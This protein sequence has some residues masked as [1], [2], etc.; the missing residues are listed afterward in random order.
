MN[1]SLYKFC[2]SE[3][4]VDILLLTG[5]YC[6]PRNGISLTQKSHLLTTDEI[7]RLA[8]L[9]VKQGVTKIRLTGGEPSVHKDLKF[10]IRECCIHFH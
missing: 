3:I 8:E 7:L 9:F 5:T 1:Q 6:M 2:S 4:N 10:I